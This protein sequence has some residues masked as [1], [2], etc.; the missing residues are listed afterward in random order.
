MTEYGLK[1]ICSDPCLD[2]HFPPEVVFASSRWSA[3]EFIDGSNQ[4]VTGST[5][6]DVF[7]FG[8]FGVELFTGKV[9]FNEP[10]DHNVLLL[11]RQGERPEKPVY[12]EAVGLTPEVWNVL[13]RCWQQNPEQRPTMKEV[14]EE[15]EGFVGGDGPNTFPKCV[16]IVM[17]IPSSP[18]A[19]FSPPHDW[20]I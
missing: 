14:V 15:L 2:S 3:P 6:G 20:I 5:A 18:S 17:V 12:A 19:P 16:Q 11:I 7:A 4:D 10:I 9:P 13:E 1:P 8:M